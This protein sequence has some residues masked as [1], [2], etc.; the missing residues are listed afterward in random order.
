MPAE[1]SR[2]SDGSAPP[3]ADPD[4]GFSLSRLDRSVDPAD[5]F[6]EFATGTWRRENP[7]PSDKSRWGAFNE[8]LDQNFR[9]LRT[10]LERTA[11]DPALP[12]ASPSKLVGDLFASAL[13]TA[14]REELRF[15]PLADDL[16][17]VDG[18]A[19]V[20]DLYRTLAGLHRLGFEGFFESYVYPDKRNSAIYAFYL[21]QGGLSLPDRDYY[22][23]PSFA[24]V[25]AAYRVHLDRSFRSLGFDPD[26]AA[27]AT[28]T[29][30]EIETELAQTSRRRSDLRDED[31]NYHRRTT[32]E[33]FEANPQTPWRLYLAEREV[34]TAPYV[35]VGQPEFFEAL[36]HALRTHSMEEWK[37]YLRWHVLRGGAPFLHEAAEASDFDFFHRTLLGQV[38]PEPTWK[39]AALVV[40][41]LLGEAL[42]ELY[43]HE[44]FPPEARARMKELVGDLRAVF[45]DRLRKLPWMAEATRERALAKFA[46]FSAKIGHPDRFRDYSA[47][48]IRR[49]D[50]FGNVRRARAFEVHRQA[51]RV[52]QPVDRTEWGMTPPT[53]N[54]YFSPVKNEI[55][56][57]AG[58]LQP[59]FFD[60]SLDDGVNYGG[61]GAVIGH[62]ITH[63]YDDQ[64]RKFDL[65]G[66]L[67][68]WW[69]EDDAREFQRRA[70]EVVEEYNHFEPLPGLTVN[71]EL[72]LGE[73]LA[74][75]GGLSIAFEALERRLARSP[76]RRRT[77][78]GFTPEQRFFLSWAQVWRQ[79]SQEAA[80]RRLLIVDPHAPGE[81]RVRG[82]VENLDSFFEA[83]GVAPGRPMWRPKEA[84]VSIW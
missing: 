16:A 29:V 47:V 45:Q 26:R 21:D 58:I 59:P 33:L 60:A 82:A 68:D 51:V 28:R 44:H 54:A 27:A 65:E 2:P 4:P 42:G 84:R 38:E 66:N 24:E 25:R 17:T 55:V 56:F 10:I 3:V 73:N 62:E 70:H 11:G 6:Y 23:E 20:D 15:Q 39:R 50:Y 77:I 22:L 46:R 40:D 57:P 64:G 36:D 12:E 48:G 78:D 14:R 52:G 74:D 79:N 34:G 30:V 61:I 71:G 69:T 67:S 83:F 5:D 31:K 49:D 13:D 63:G 1:P 75:L 43:V 9:H 19:S 32:A 76:E 35:V 80:A 41:Q 7:V 53:V 8:L 37:E 81:F 72:T 18:I